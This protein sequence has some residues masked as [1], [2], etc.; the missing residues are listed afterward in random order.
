MVY[1]FGKDEFLVLAEQLLLLGGVLW[2]QCAPDQRQQN[3]S[4]QPEQSQGIDL[5]D[6]RLQEVGI[7]ALV[8]VHQGLATIS[9]V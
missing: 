1:L 6:R 8:A 2:P 4:L 5:V 3:L 9:R 7:E